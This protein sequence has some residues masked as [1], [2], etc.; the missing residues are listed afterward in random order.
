MKVLLAA[1][2][3]LVL[4]GAVWAQ[5]PTAA[6]DPMGGADVASPWHD[7]THYVGIACG[8]LALGAVA[9]GGVLFFGFELLGRKYNFP[10]RKKARTAHIALG[11]T[12]IALGTVHFVVRL[13]QAGQ[14]QL[15]M[16]PP[17]LA[18]VCFMLVLVTGILRHWTPK[19]LRKHWQVFPWLHRAV[20]LGAL[21]YLT[22][23]SLY[24]YHKFMG[25]GR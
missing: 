17:M 20:V 5:A 10:A 12:A 21:Y 8:V 11:I 14:F 18:Q 13:I 24:Q 15:S 16:S 6:D 22:R 23:H 9:V 25:S 4:A 2:V 1:T 7:L 3:L 19:A